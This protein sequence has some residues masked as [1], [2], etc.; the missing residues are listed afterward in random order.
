V[1]ELSSNL[2]PGKKL[3]RILETLDDSLLITDNQGTILYSN[4]AF[5]LLLGAGRRAKKLPKT[6]D[7]ICIISLQESE[8]KSGMTI[9][10]R[11]KKRHAFHDYQCMLKSNSLD[12]A[13]DPI[14]SIKGAQLSND[15]GELEG[16]VFTFINIT[17]SK[18][19]SFQQQQFIHTIGHELKHPLS[20]MK[21]YLYYLKKFAN[22]KKSDAAEYVEKMSNQI[23]LLT[24][25][26]HD[27]LDITKISSHQFMITPQEG[28]INAFLER[29]ITDLQPVYKIHHLILVKGDPAMV[30]F[31]EMRMQQV[32]MNLLSNAA[33]YS[34]DSHEITVKVTTKKKKVLISVIDKGIGIPTAEIHSIFRPYFRSST[35]LG[36]EYKGLGL[37]LYLCSEIVEKHRG[38]ISAQSVRGGGTTITISLPLID[39]K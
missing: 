34:P 15:K 6:L 28:E 30:Y 18:E 37:G 29:V 5:K 21:A 22:N 27:V 17:E 35:T 11:L 12:R 31:D 26:L 25:M 39:G 38:T 10:Q 23:D 32:M 19:S 24:N 16:A 2:L 3:H 9:L 33:K 20:C 36:K 14:I 8:I 1:K 4:L 7:D 13:D